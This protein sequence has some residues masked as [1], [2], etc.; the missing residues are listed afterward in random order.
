MLRAQL[1]ALQAFHLRERPEEAHTR[2]F[3]NEIVFYVED[4][5]SICF[6][7]LMSFIRVRDEYPESEGGL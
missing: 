7:F 1:D 3:Q 4:V 5:P 6:R 2:V